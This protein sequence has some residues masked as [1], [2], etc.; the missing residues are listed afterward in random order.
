MSDPAGGIP[1]NVRAAEA[2]YNEAHHAE[3]QEKYQRQAEET[4]LEQRRCG[5]RAA[6]ERERLAIADETRA[7]Q[8]SRKRPR[9]DEEPTISSY[10]DDDAKMW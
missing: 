10:S 4:W 1:M 9:E 8:G 6:A 7:E 2:L 5:A 3:R